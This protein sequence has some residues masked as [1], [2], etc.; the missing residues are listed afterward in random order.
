VHVH[1][2]AVHKDVREL[3]LP[4]IDDIVW[5]I[6]CLLNEWNVKRKTIERTERRSLRELGNELI[7]CLIMPLDVT[8]CQQTRK[9]VS[10]PL[11]T[12]VVLRTHNGDGVAPWFQAGCLNIKRKH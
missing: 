8:N 9:L 11:A 12:L 2:F 5:H 6:E 4:P 3:L 1:A 7:F 10:A